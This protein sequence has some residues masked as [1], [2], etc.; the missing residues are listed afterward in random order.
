MELNVTWNRAIR[1][2]WS[3]AWRNL[4]AIL[5]S[6]VLGAIVGFIVGMI[7]GSFGA[8]VHTI[9]WVTAPLGAILGLVISIIPIKMILGKDFG[10]FRLV[11]LGDDAPHR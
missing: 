2:W 10:E 5:A 7:L 1:V 6:M 8:S 9:Q 4:I 3:L 11:L